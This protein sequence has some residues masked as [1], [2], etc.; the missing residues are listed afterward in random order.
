MPV[1]KHKPIIYASEAV[2]VC[3]FSTASAVSGLVELAA[4]AIALNKLD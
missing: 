2:R 4:W 3:V 1:L